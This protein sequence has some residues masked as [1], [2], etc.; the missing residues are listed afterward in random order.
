MRPGSFYQEQRRR[1]FPWWTY[2][3]VAAVVLSCLLMALWVL[4][5]NSG[6]YSSESR[7]PQTM[8]IFTEDIFPDP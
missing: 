5:D 3:I 2:V 6:G 4:Q 1:T 8:P 7:P